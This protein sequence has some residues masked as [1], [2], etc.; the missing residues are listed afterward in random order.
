MELNPTVAGVYPQW[1][2]RNHI[3][4]LWIQ[5]GKNLANKGV[6]I[7]PAW[8]NTWEEDTRVDG[9]CRAEIFNVRNW[10]LWKWLPSLLWWLMHL[11][12]VLM[13]GL[14]PG[15]VF[16]GAQERNWKVWGIVWEFSFKFYLLER[17]LVSH[18]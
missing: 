2:L 11:E 17:S 4:K 8:P 3:L 16:T 6:P 10:S 7:W 9:E 5:Q 18:N 13:S 14:A 1:C 15:D 12:Q